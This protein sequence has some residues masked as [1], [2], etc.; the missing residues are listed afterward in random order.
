MS[1]EMGA[2]DGIEFPEPAN[3]EVKTVENRT[4]TYYLGR[5][6]TFYQ[7]VTDA[8][9]YTVRQVRHY[10]DY[11]ISVYACHENFTLCSKHA[12]TSART[13]QNG[14]I[15]LQCHVYSNFFIHF[16]FFFHFILLFVF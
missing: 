3:S 14:T 13:K 11:A 1:A 7:E 2:I 12:V 8:T 4:N 10:A 15:L 6:A 16:F 9:S 5:L